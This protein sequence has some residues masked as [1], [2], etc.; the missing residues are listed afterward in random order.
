MSK[1]NLVKYLIIALLCVIFIFIIIH[2]V[3]TSLH[4]TSGKSLEKSLN[5]TIPPQCD[6]TDNTCGNNMYHCLG[7]NAIRGCRNQKDGPF[8][9]IDCSS[10]CF[11]GAL[12]TNPCDVV[13]CPPNSSCNNGI[14]HCN[15]GWSG[16]NCDKPDQPGT[17]PFCDKKPPCSPNYYYCL[18]GT[19]QNGCSKD[20]WNSND[21]TS[22]CIYKSCIPNCNGK[23]CGDE[24]GCSGTCKTGTCERTGD[25]CQ[26]GVCKQPQC[27]P[28]CNGNM[29][30]DNDGCGGTCKRG[31]CPT[32]D[33]C[34]DGKCQ[35][36]VTDYTLNYN[37]NDNYLKIIPDP[38]P[39]NNY[40]ILLG[41][42]GGTTNTKTIAQK[43]VAESMKTYY[44]EQKKAGKKLLFIATLGDN[45]YWTGQNNKTWETD[46]INIYGPD[47][48]SVPWFSIMGNH[49]FGNDDP[50]CI[51]PENNNNPNEVKKVGGTSYMCNQLDNDKQ[52]DSRQRSSN[53][54]NYVMPDF[55]YHYTI[56]EL[57]FELIALSCDYKD[58][59]G[60]IGGDGTDLN[61]SGH[62][63]GA[64][65]TSVN[66][67]GADVM[68]DK[69]TKIYNAGQSLLIERAQ[70]STEKNILITNHYSD[71]CDYLRN[72]FIDN[73]SEDSQTV[74]SAGGHIHNTSCT[75]AQDDD[76]C[77]LILSGGGGGCCGDDVIENASGFYTVHFYK[78]SS[79]NSIKMK[80]EKILYPY[81]PKKSS[82]Y[83]KNGSF[84]VNVP[85]SPDSH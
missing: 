16:A 47:L 17:I 44:I 32:G 48:V 38:I 75:K 42:W 45:F 74:I 56:S 36:P 30:G 39:D 29:C 12:P 54:K 11:K 5:S 71:E 67:G 51:C 2:V 82:T 69:L 13:T 3:R 55:C 84:I 19:G 77:L 72:K 64:H 50:W 4:R 43:K 70:T 65:Q 62:E 9:M 26:N 22:Q 31:S 40:F 27:I 15:S 85:H 35:I 23:L 33:T 7:G 78:D 81:N 52:T 10:Q 53:T 41:D 63:C 61:C 80:T 20:V 8:P 46:W 37:K 28:T 18:T 73:S 34:V 58:S 76:L 68:T 79:D 14:C 6:N 49:D 1:H 60:G 83:H 25:I 24:D 21:C 57:N 66:C 59:P